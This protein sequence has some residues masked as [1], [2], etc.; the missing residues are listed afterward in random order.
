MVLRGVAP[1]PGTVYS[2]PPQ[3]MK[4]PRGQLL[5][6]WD[7]LRG[8]L[9]LVG[10]LAAVGAVAGFAVAMLQ[11]PLYRARTGSRYPKFE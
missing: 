10:L 4:E 3:I 11:H 6:Y 9:V 5:E 1:L 8:K 7:A 2:Y